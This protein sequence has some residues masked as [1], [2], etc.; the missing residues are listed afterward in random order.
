[1]ETNKIA[2]HRL[3]QSVVNYFL[4]KDDL[5]ALYI[6]GSVAEGSADEFSELDFRV[7]ILTTIYTTALL[8]PALVL[9]LILNNEVVKS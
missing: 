4:A 3:Y 7:V 5:E 9:Q 6:Q 1:M 8:V 2:L